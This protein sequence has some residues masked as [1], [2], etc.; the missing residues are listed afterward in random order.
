MLRGAKTHSLYYLQAESIVG[1]SDHTEDNNS[2]FWHLRLGHLSE[3]GLNGLLQKGILKNK[4]GFRVQ[5]CE[6]CSLHKAAI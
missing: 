4:E 3:K 5:H 2:T 6:D 1:T